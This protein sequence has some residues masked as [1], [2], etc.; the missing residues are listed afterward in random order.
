MKNKICEWMGLI[1]GSVDY[2]EEVSRQEWNDALAEEQAVNYFTSR[3]A[4]VSDFTNHNYTEVDLP[5]EVY[6]DYEETMQ[7]FLEMCA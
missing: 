2:I 3:P 7:E 5:G 1:E 4:I 6:P